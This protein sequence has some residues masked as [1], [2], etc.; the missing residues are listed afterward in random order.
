MTDEED[1]SA[2]QTIREFINTL[3]Q[4]YALNWPVDLAAKSILGILWDLP[5]VVTKDDANDAYIVES[6]VN[7]LPSQLPARIQLIVR[8]LPDPE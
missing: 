4:L 5:A 2:S 1:I 3:N 6:Q 7:L 8:N